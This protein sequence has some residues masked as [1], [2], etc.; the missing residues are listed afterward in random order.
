MRNGFN[1][2]IS[3]TKSFDTGLQSIGKIRLLPDRSL[4]FHGKENGQEKLKQ[5]D[6]DTGMERTCVNVETFHKK[7]W[8]SSLVEYA[9]RQY[10]YNN[11]RSRYSLAVSHR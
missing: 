10:R 9:D 3:V 11:G 4:A 7:L 8:A 5:Y 2:S 6:L 1:L